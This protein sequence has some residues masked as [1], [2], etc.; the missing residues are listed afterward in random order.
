[1]KSVPEG[2]AGF[3]QNCD[4]PS[5]RRYTELAQALHWITAAFAVALLPVA[6]V[7]TSVARDDPAR[8][9]LYDLH[10]SLGLTIW[11][12]MLVRLS[13]RFTHPAPALGPSTPRWVDW[14]SKASHWAI[15]AAFLIMPVTGFT[16]SSAGGHGVRFW[17]VPLPS[18]P[19]DEALSRAAGEL[20]DTGAW[21]VYALLLLHV[22]ATAW[23]VG[24]RRD[25]VLQRMIPSQTRGDPG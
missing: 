24:V 19:R 18:L 2:P 13:W 1:M 20:H 14:S 21:I 25:G 22:A 23:H 9:R 5:G 8:G 7:M 11:L 12:L 6:W 10:K 4:L 16:T 3:G 15:Y 17:G